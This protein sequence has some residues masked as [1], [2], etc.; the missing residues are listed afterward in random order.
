LLLQGFWLLSDLLIH[1]C[2]VSSQVVDDSLQN[3]RLEVFVL[4][5]VPLFLVDVRHND[6]QIL[7]YRI[8]VKDNS[9]RFVIQ[10]TLLLLHWFLVDL[11]LVAPNK[12]HCCHNHLTGFALLLL[13]PDDQ[14]PKE[15][16][17]ILLKFLI[18]SELCQLI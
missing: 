16:V 4:L 7:I 3:L 18:L 11:D 14:I 5:S 2:A 10:I 9:F 6:I 8:T 1:Q 13:L 12:V 17:H 15:P